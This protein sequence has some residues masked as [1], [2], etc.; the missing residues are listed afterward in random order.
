MIDDMIPV[1]HKFPNHQDIKVYP[2][3]DLHV[4]SPQFD[5]KKWDAFRTRLLAEP[6]SRI[7]IAGDMLNNGIKSSKSNCY[8]EVLRPS[9]QKQWLTEQLK[10][11]ADKILCGCSG[12]HEQRSSREVDLNPLF[13][14]FAKLNIEHL[15]R[16]NGCFLIMR[17]GPEDKAQRKGLP[18]NTRPTYATYITHGNGGGMY[19]GSSANKTERLGSVIDGL[20]VIISGHVHK[21]INFAVGKLCI[22]KHND[23]VIEQQFRVVIATSWLTFGGYGIAKSFTPTAYMLQEIIYSSDEKLIRVTS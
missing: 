4:G 20:D 1:I 8:E 10:P 17:F 5:S 14:V 9:Q 21:G 13:D 18:G 2:I 6:N 3:S 22:D 15:Y 7:V 23:N 19:V 11:V 12:N 16:E